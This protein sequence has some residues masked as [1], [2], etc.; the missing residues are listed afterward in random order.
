MQAA[1]ATSTTAVADI[2]LR[3]IRARVLALTRP[4][5]RPGVDGLVEPDGANLVLLTAVSPSWG[6]DRVTSGSVP[7]REHLRE[8]TGGDEMVSAIDA[9]RRVDRLRV[10]GEVVAVL[11]L[12]RGE[13]A[14]R[15]RPP[16]VAGGSMHVD[17]AAGDPRGAAADRQVVA[18]QRSGGVE[19]LARD[20]VLGG[21]DERR[22]RA[23]A[24]RA[25]DVV[26]LHVGSASLHPQSFS[27]ASVLLEPGLGAV[28]VAD[29]EPAV[30]VANEVANAGVLGV[31]LDRERPSARRIEHRELGVDVVHPLRYAIGHYAHGAG[32]HAGPWHPRCADSQTTRTA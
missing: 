16:A 3:L 6:R 26:E 28:L 12:P 9:P 2:G 1:N 18:R 15:D 22:E 29:R 24:D 30:L 10:R 13:L 21:Q 4:G 27:S 32:E 7:S 11:A 14:R 20:L 19:R 31:V 25:R 5:H 8:R 17:D 23:A